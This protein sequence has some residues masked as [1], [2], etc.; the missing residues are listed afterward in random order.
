V[1]FRS[2]VVVLPMV[3]AGCAGSPPSSSGASQTPVS[4]QEA[5]GDARQ[6]AKAHTEL[7]MVY[8]R[9]GR[10]NV[11]LDEARI[12][13]DS[14]PSYPLGYNLLGLAQM[15]LRDNKVA[16]ENFLRALGLAP[17]DPEV[18]NNYGWFLCRTGREQQ[19]FGYF[20]TA[21]RSQLYSEPTKP[22][23][24]AGMCALSIKDDKAAE[25]FLL[26]A[27]RA[28]PGN[29]EAQFLLADICY[30]GERLNEARN[31][32]AEIHRA[33]EPSPQTAW[34]GLRLERKLG[35][36]EAEAR[37]AAQLRRKFQDSREYQLLMQ[38]RFE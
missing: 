25:E 33:V 11:A 30:R 37:Y 4:Q 20:E 29:G 8:L 31:R 14:D 2:L 10:L 15:S 19:S 23:T 9:E 17:T 16:E 35:D 38:G 3:L 13:I 24:N 5:V 28:D 21:S 34:L 26:R 27:L 7:G 36:R 1:R 6:R 22:L 12:A 18:N 32:L